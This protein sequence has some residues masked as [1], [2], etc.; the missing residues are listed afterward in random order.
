MEA[1]WK[2]LVVS[3]VHRDDNV[4]QVLSIL[5]EV[6][7]INVKDAESTLGARGA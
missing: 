6:C 2:D 4:P 7:S 3:S 5:V 1:Q